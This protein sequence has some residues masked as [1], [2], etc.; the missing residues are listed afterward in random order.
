MPATPSDQSCHFEL[1]GIY[2]SRDLFS[3]LGSE[4]STLF[5][6]KRSI[7]VGPGESIISAGDRPVDIVLIEDGQAELSH[8]KDGRT[9]ID[10]HHEGTN[11]VFGI[12]ESL[13]ETSFDMS[14][15]AVT[16]CQ[17]GLMDANE[18]FEQVR[19]N[20]GLSFRL[21]EVVAGLYIQTLRAARGN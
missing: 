15:K 13:S 11:P 16:K 7:K 2:L 17:I 4:S 1:Q 12:L 20:P 18:F 21:A 10:A 5:S 8:A 3:S 6:N 19:G 9:T 14:L